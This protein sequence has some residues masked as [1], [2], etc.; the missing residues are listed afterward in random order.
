MCAVCALQVK[1]LGAVV[2]DCGC[3][4]E[5]LDKI[6]E[7]YWYLGQKE[8]VP[9]QWPSEFSTSYNKDT[10]MEL[11]LNGTDSLVYLSV[12][13]LPDSHRDQLLYQLT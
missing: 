7:A 9:I 10:P 1:E 8:S 12:G 13:Q 4:A 3:L 2:Y 6:F 5:D 11:Q